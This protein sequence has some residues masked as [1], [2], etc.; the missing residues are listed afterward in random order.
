MTVAAVIAQ[1]RASAGLTQR[2]LAERAG[3]SQPAVAKLESGHTRP[4]FA[5][6]ERLAAAAGFTVRIEL[7]P[8]AAPDT[9]VDAYKRDVDR[10]LL[11]ENLRKTIDQR[12]RSLVELQDFGHELQRAVR[13][14]RRKA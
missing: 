8:I 9:V 7:V 4:A 2:E 12:L 5:T 11:R 13:G 3:T 6:I 14:R 1:A 10:T